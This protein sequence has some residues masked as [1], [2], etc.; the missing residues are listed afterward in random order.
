M[1]FTP[2]YSPGDAFHTR[3]YTS[4]MPLYTQVYTSGM[5][6]YTPGYTSGWGIPGLYASLYTL[7]VYPGLY[8]SL[9]TLGGI[10][11]GTPPWVHPSAHIG[12]PGP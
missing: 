2:G 3:V 1:P 7:G 4:G 10:Y 12:L 8:V 11:L 9:Y 5:P 6:L